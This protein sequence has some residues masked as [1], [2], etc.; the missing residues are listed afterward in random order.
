M[1]KIHSAIIADQIR[2]EHNGKSIIIGVYSGDIILPKF[3]VELRL[4]FWIDVELS[5]IVR[6]SNLILQLR[7]RI[8]VPN[9]GPSAQIDGT[10]SINI[11]LPKIENTQPKG[12]QKLRTNLVINDVPAKIAG[13][14]TLELAMR[15]AD[16]RWKKILSKQLVAAE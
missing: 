8:R 1:I 9:E 2:R 10:E 6:P 15:V 4:A 14:G 3:P 13:P 16:K 5:P 11:Q 12:S 7:V